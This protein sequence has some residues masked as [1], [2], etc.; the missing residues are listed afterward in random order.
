MKS[1]ILA[2][3][4]HPDTVNVGITAVVAQ[5]EAGFSVTVRDDQA[6][7]FVGSA[8]IYPSLER[9]LAYARTIQGA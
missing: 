3:L 2:E 1:I 8:I 6:G 7:Q 5:I 9:A 4:S